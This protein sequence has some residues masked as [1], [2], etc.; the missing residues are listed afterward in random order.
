M[1]STVWNWLV[2]LGTAAA[3][4]VRS[5]PWRNEAAAT[6]AIVVQRWRKPRGYSFSV[7]SGRG[8]ASATSNCSWGRPA[9]PSRTIAACGAS[10]SAIDGIPA[11]KVG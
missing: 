3:T 4:I 6:E 10:V 5:R 1:S 11:L 9:G 7:S 2:K 8:D